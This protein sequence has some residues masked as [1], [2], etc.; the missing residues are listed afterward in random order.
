MNAATMPSF[1]TYGQ[2]SSDNYGAHTLVFTD[3][4]GNDFY[5]SYQTLVAVRVRGHGLAVRANDWGP[6]TGKHLNWIDRGDRKAR[7]SAEDFTATV[8]AWLA[9]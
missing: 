5:Y 9:A 6:T 4:N 3:T 2:Y 8:A 1:S 7:L